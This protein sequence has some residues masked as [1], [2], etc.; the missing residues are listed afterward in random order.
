MEGPPNERF[1]E[2]A[3]MKINASWFKV[4]FVSKRKSSTKRGRSTFANGWRWKAALVL[5]NGI[6]RM[7]G[8]N[9]CIVQTYFRT[10]ASASVWHNHANGGG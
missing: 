6:A 5:L 2:H 8:A 4:I 3:I 10:C 9:A 1:G 7:L